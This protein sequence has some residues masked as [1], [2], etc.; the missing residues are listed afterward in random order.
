MKINKKEVMSLYLKCMYFNKEEKPDPNRYITVCIFAGSGI[1]IRSFDICTLN[2]YFDIIN[3]MILTL[4]DEDDNIDFSKCNCFT[5]E[6]L[7]YLGVAAGLIEVSLDSSLSNETLL[8]YNIPS[9]QY[10]KFKYIHRPSNYIITKDNSNVKLVINHTEMDI[11]NDN[12]ESLFNKTADD[13][14]FINYLERDDEPTQF[15]I[16]ILKEINDLYSKFEFSP[17]KKYVNDAY[18]QRAIEI[19]NM[20]PK[21][22]FS[23]IPDKD[24][25]VMPY[26]AIH[27]SYNYDDQKSWQLKYMDSLKY[28][29]EMV[30][31]KQNFCHFIV[32][33]DAFHSLYEKIYL[34]DRD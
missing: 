2:T 19:W 15:D 27:F 23:F 7:S 16:D 4:K 13:V 8:L 17:D 22:R 1:S 25:I 20:L 6:K 10:H 9:L 5:A 3:D 14:K 28:L 32:I 30:S 12:I 26:T 31:A 29:L 33:K 21:Y 18:I 24:I 11:E 34:F